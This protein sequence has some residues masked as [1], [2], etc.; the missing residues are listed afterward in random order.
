[1]STVCANECNTPAML[2]LLSIVSVYVCLHIHV[3]GIVIAVISGI[4]VL[5]SECN[6]TLSTTESAD[7]DVREDERKAEV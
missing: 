1:M 6:K 2:C 3:G 4:P 7:Q 5:L